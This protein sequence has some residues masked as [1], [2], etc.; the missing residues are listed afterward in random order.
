M[1]FTKA[2]M[3]LITRF[4]AL[5]VEH[6]DKIFLRHLSPANGIYLC[7]VNAYNEVDNSLSFTP[8]ERV[9]SRTVNNLMQKGYTQ[10]VDK[11]FNPIPKE[12]INDLNSGLIGSILIN[13]PPFHKNE[14]IKEE[15]K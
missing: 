2:Q 6:K 1:N 14:P 11:N 9:H 10:A 3:K 8:I 12:R 5:S 15:Q 13:L 7:K 4:Q